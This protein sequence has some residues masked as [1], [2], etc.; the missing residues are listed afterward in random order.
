[1]ANYSSASNITWTT[2]TTTTDSTCSTDYTWSYWT[3]G[4][5]TTSS[6][7]YTTSYQPPINQKSKELTKEEIARMQA[8]QAKFEAEAKERQKKLDEA[9]EKSRQ[10]L[11]SLLDKNQAKRLEEKGEFGFVGPSGA[12]YTIRKGVAGNIIMDKEGQRTRL[13]CHTKDHVPVYDNMASQLIWLKFCEE[14]FVNLANKTN[15]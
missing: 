15:L 3:S 2:W 4:T 13:C 1:M 7:T 6:R 10:L 11:V 8:A 9:V 12:L 5:A 14:E